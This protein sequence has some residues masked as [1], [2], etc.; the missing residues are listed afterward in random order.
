MSESAATTMRAPRVE[1]KRADCP[2]VEDTAPTSSTR[3]RANR[4]SA[5][6]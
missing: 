3:R 1:R 6:M 5:K 2:S 4:L